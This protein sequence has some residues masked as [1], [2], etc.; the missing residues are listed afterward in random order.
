MQL[1]ARQN[2]VDTARIIRN[3]VEEPV[4]ICKVGEHGVNNITTLPPRRVPC[5]TA[6]VWSPA[7]PYPACTSGRYRATR[8]NTKVT[9]KQVI[10]ELC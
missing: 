5:N 3:M 7:G 8:E 9:W 4:R 2:L 10:I 1:L 6:S